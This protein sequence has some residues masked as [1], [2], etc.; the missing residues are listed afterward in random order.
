M[1]RNKIDKKY[2]V[3]IILIL[4]TL[5]LAFL[6]SVIKSDR[7]LTPVEQMVKDT[8]TAVS[9]T[10]YKP[11]NLIKDKINQ[12]RDK[13]NL[14]EKYQEQQEKI[15]NVDNLQA[16]QADLEKQLNEMKKLLEL[17]NTSAEYEYLNA[18]VVNRNVG[19]WYNTITIDKGKNSG[20]EKDM[21]VMVADG[22]IG[23]ITKVTN[24]TSTVKLLTNNDSTMPLSV[25]INIGDK[26]IFG[27]LNGYDSETKHLIVEGISGNDKI[28][29]DSE[30]V[31]TGLSD[32]SPSGVLIGKVE[33]V[34]TDNFGLAKIVEVS[35]KVNFDDINYVTILKRKDNDN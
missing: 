9:K 14:Y 8:F 3:L 2:I 12:D 30:V 20:V 17:N 33:S 27:I 24:F 5:F 26:Y 35:S 1:R 21:V 15:A 31:T 23:K 22:L 6:F 32:N 18:T 19:Y 10:V 7:N 11:I 4:I 29:I 25:K 28:P 13:S 16:K 34:K